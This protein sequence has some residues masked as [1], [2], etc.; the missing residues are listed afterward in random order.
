[1][2]EN[3]SHLRIAVYL[4][5]STDL[6][7][8]D[9][10]RPDIERYLSENRLQPDEIVYFSENESAWK[11]GH[12]HELA[13]LMEEIRSGKRK[14]N[15][16]IVWSFDRLTRGGAAELIKLYD[17]FI[18]RGV[19]II[20]V[21]EP[22]SN[23]PPEFMPVILSFVGMLAKMESDRRS[24]RTRAGMARARENGTRSGVGIG[25][26]GKDNPDKPRRRAG[27]LN[28][29]LKAKNGGQEKE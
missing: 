16:V 12:Q 2:N 15:V 23:I 4:R 28:R 5:V 17:F 21:K 11:Q 1:M 25:K 24:E 3:Y 6:Q 19:Q 8:V 27:Y 7:T 13:R 20:S 10:Q 29:Y 26:R 9:N 22:W 14:Y 18:K